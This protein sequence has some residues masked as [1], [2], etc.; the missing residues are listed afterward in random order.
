MEKNKDK[1]ILIVLIIVLLLLICTVLFLIMNH[2]KNNVT[3][4]PNVVENELN[5]ETLNNISSEDAQNS[6]SSFS[7]K[8]LKLEDAKKNIIYSPLS[9][10]YALKMLSD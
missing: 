4:I 1:T 9:I 3:P 7:F 6:S 8:F 5:S 10:K 2:S